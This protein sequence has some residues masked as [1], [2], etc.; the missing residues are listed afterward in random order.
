MLPLTEDDEEGIM[1]HDNFMALLEKSVLTVQLPYITS[2]GTSAILF[3][4][5]FRNMPKIVKVIAQVVDTKFASSEFGRKAASLF[6]TLQTTLP[7]QVLQGAWNALSPEEMQR[8][9]QLAAA[10]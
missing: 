9:S 4:Q 1:C 2:P 6:R 5:D 3:G 10:S 7:A 8:V